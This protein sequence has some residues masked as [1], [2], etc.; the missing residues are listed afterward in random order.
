M[1]IYNFLKTHQKFK[2]G[3]LFALKMLVSFTKTNV[4]KH[5]RFGPLVRIEGILYHVLGRWSSKGC[6]NS[7][8]N[9]K[10]SGYFST[11]YILLF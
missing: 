6:I 9:R 10:V 7:T 2:M 8:L 5:I 4:R 3:Q 11:T 1:C